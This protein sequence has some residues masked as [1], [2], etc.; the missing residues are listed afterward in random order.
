MN[1]SATQKSAIYNHLSLFSSF[2]TLICCAL[3]SLL[4]LFGLGA[5]MVSLLSAVPWLVTLSQHKVWVFAI[6]GALIASNLVYV[7]ALAPRLKAEGAACSLDAPDACKT[8]SRFSRFVLWVSV[9]IYLAGF[10]TAFVLG[11]ILLRMHS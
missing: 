2:G 7:Y 9:A 4:V 3:P 8:A 6:S 10:F 11:P 5:T 1:N